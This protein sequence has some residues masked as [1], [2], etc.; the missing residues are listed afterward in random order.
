MNSWM[1]TRYMEV[2]YTQKS[3]TYRAFVKDNELTV[4][5]ASSLW[6][7]MDE[8]ESTIDDGFFLVTMDD[9]RPFASSP[10][11]RHDN[12]YALNFADAHAAV[13]K[14]RDPNLRFSNPAQGYANSI[15]WVRLKDM[16]T[17]RYSVP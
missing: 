14:I 5:G 3:T 13:Q 10:G 7:I 9:S 6:V 16:S 12:A 15:D 2:E 17:L 11:N 8:H 4:A 1:G